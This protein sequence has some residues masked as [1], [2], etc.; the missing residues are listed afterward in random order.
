MQSLYQFSSFGLLFLRVAIASSF[1][2]HGTGKLSMWK[3]GPD[4]QMPK[5][6]LNIF[7]ILSVAEPL[8]AVAILL[9]FLTQ[10]AAL[11]LFII[12]LGALYFKVSVWKRTFSQEGGW[13]LDVI[14][15]TSVFLLFLVGAGA[16]SLDTFLAI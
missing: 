10:Y 8:G 4:G 6:M 2:V 11:G 9:G 15:L 5:K 7:K 12:M 16:F 3:A 14:I 1:W 13:E